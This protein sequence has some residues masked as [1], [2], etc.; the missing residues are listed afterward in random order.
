M[1]FFRSKWT[2]IYKDF[3]GTMQGNAPIMLSQKPNA[4]ASVMVGRDKSES[5]FLIHGATI[6][7]LLIGFISIIIFSFLVRIKPKS[8]F[9]STATKWYIFKST[10]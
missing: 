1:N 7:F 8:Y 4:P 9:D 5:Y 10:R 3:F 2:V 6:T